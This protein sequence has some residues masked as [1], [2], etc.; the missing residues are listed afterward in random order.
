MN[1]SKNVALFDFCGTIANFQTADPFVDY[2]RLHSKRFA[3]LFFKH[4]H[5]LLC[6]LRII[7]ILTILFPRKSVNKRL[8]ALQLRGFSYEELDQMAYGYYLDKVRPNLIVR[9]LDELKRRQ[10]EGW[11][12]VIVSGGYDLYINYFAKEYGIEMKDII[13]TSFK[14]K[15]GICT[16]HFEGKDCLFTEKVNRL[17]KYMKEYQRYSVAYSDSNSD[18][19]FLS[20]ANVG[21]VVR[22]SQIESWDVEGLFEE[23]V[24]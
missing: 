18:I 17:N 8:Y 15:D 21:Y 1:R 13:C 12:I 5:R 2:V 4:L 24:V 6:L 11:R 9:T 14:F 20:W 19:P 3:V 23:I 10:N 7:K 16:G 22:K